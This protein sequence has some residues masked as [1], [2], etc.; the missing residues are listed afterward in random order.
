M[1]KYIVVDL[2][3]GISDLISEEEAKE[4]IMGCDK[5]VGDVTVWRSEEYLVIELQ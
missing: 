2:Y 4:A 1:K 5:V 3:E